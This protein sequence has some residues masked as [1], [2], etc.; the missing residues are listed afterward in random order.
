MSKGSIVFISD[1]SDIGTDTAV[2]QAMQRLS[3]KEF[4]IRLSQGIYYYPKVDKLLGM[5]KP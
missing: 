3:K 2:R 4:I 5:I 1:F